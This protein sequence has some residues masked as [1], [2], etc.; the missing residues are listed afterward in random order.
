MKTAVAEKATR[1]AKAPQ[2]D[3]ELSLFTFYCLLG[4]VLIVS[5]L[6]YTSIGYFWGK[7]SR[8]EVFFAECAREMIATN[9]YVTPL[10]HNQP[11]FDKPILIYWFIIAM[12]KNFGFT[13]LA[14]RIPSI[15][16][17]LGAVAITAFSGAALFGRRVG[18]LGAAMMATA[19]MFLSF[20]ASCMSDMA[21]VLMDCITLTC[22]YAGLQSDT[23]RTLLWFL[24]A[25]SMGFAFLIKGPVG[26][27]LPS[28]SALIFMTFTKQL[29]KI[30]FVHV[31]TAVV[32]LA[33]I[34]SPWFIAAYKANGMSAITYFFVHENLQ[35]FAGETYD[36]HR[37]FWY[38]AGSLFSGF[39]PWSIFLPLALFD[40][41]KGWYRGDKTPTIDRQLF[42]W[43]WIAVLVA[44]FSCSRGKCDYYTLP[45]FPAA[46]LLSAWSLDA[47]MRKRTVLI[48]WTLGIFSAV[49]IGSGLASGYIA[50][51]ILASSGTFLWLIVPSSFCLFG[52]AGLWAIFKRKPYLSFSL[53]FAGLAAGMTCFAIA[54]LPGVTRLIPTE[55]YALLIKAAPPAAIVYMQK[56]LYSWRDEL[57][58]LTGRHP[59]VTESNADFESIIKRGGQ[60]LLVMD[61]NNYLNLSA[62]SRSKLKLVSKDYAITKPITPALAIRTGGQMTDSTP[63][64]VLTHI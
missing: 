25:V 45:V 12:F 43:T 63:V 39:A 4:A 28:V 36:A 6:L 3:S 40:F 5:C 19:F 24:A 48:T 20:A 57:S 59:E 38:T 34:S 42:L 1:S 62:A 21:L 30:K 18:L 7:F 15:Y 52:I 64:V 22:I 35:R 60:F 50:S 56:S 61:E 14:A 27:V 41:C 2:A 31:A 29:N 33:V 46:A 54:V 17:G 10:Y 49:L 58:F 16:A 9:N 32:T 37:P 47:Q 11:F 13:H 44:F 51:R 55:K 26:L 53:S 8:A 23:R